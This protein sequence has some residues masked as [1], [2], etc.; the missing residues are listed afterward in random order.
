MQMNLSTDDATRV[1]IPSELGLLVRDQIAIITIKRAEKRNAL[2]L[3]L[4]RSLGKIAAHLD[5]RSDVRAVI[6]TGSGA[7][8]CAGADIAEFNEVRGDEAQVRRYDAA[9]ESCCSAIEAIG[10]P[11][12]AAINGFCMGGGCNLAMACDFRFASPGAEFSIAAARLSIV[13]GVAGTRR[14]LNLVGLVNAKRIL[15]T[16]QRFNVADALRFGLVDEI[17]DNVSD[18]A[19]QFA[20]AMT[21]NAPLSIRGSKLIL[22]GLASGAGSL[23]QQDVDTAIQRAACS[24]D[25]AQARVAF[26]QK[27]IPLFRGV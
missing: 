21:E 26:L 6:L 22:T 10:K 14:L 17:Y 13:Y 4:W 24:A 25:Y 18:A 23:S 27:R 12:I 3:E 15:F 20:T 16:A 9:Y 19:Q 2:T 11:T 5:T 8:F 7:S 1:D